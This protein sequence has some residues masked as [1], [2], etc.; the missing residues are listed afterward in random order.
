MLGG[1][2][3]DSIFWLYDHMTR[4]RGDWRLAEQHPAEGQ[5]AAVLLLPGVLHGDAAVRGAEV[6]QQRHAVLPAEVGELDVLHLPRMVIIIT[7]YSIVQPLLQL[8]LW[9]K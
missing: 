8:T 3:E 6:L 5:L 2:T 1:R 4:V 7:L 9:L